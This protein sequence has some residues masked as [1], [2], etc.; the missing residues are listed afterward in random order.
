MIM[1]DKIIANLINL[2]VQIADTL[3]YNKA[4]DLLKSYGIYSLK[5]ENL[6]K[7]LCNNYKSQ[8][9][10]NCRYFYWGPVGG[11]KVYR[12]LQEAAVD[13]TLEE[14]TRLIASSLLNDGKPSIMGYSLR[15]NMFY[16]E[17]FIKIIS[18]AL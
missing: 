14:E 5:V 15:M 12:R 10:L 1:E 3:N 16:M 17:H 9:S 11:R 18:E 2:G 4:V 13:T 7:E 8:S 6:I